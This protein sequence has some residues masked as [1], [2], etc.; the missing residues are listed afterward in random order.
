[1][2]CR[3]FARFKPCV[4]G[5]PCRP[6]RLRPCFSS[7]APALRPAASPP[8]PG[9]PSPSTPPRNS[10]AG[11]AP[12]NLPRRS[13]NPRRRPLFVHRPPWV[14]AVASSPNRRDLKTVMR[15]V[16]I[17]KMFPS[18]PNNFHSHPIAVKVHGAQDWYSAPSQIN[19]R[20]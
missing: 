11:S 10:S 16:V 13:R 19:L 3:K 8:A 18:S 12:R 15:S 9:S 17:Q 6:L 14:A 1:M 5:T 4:P 20:S 7:C 2:D